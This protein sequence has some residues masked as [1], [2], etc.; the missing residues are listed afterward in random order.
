LIAEFATVSWIALALTGHTVA[1]T[2]TPVHAAFCRHATNYKPDLGVTFIFMFKKV[3]KSVFR[4]RIRIGSGFNQ[5]SG[6]LSGSVSCKAKKIN[7]N[8]KNLEISCFEMLDVL[9]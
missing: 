6:S 8:R 3:W 4:I 9:F 2:V 1:V 5:V 7:N